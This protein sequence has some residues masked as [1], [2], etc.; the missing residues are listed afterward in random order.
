MAL[1]SPLGTPLPVG[2]ATAA[3]RA[4]WSD[5]LGRAARRFPLYWLLLSAFLAL[6][7]IALSF[8][9]ISRADNPNSAGIA[10][11]VAVHGIALGLVVL[12]ALRWPGWCRRAILTLAVA[13]LPVLA[14]TSQNVLAAGS[15]AILLGTGLWFGRELAAALLGEGDR[16]ETWLYGS[17]LGIGALGALG[18]VLGLVGWL[19]PQAIWPVVVATLLML[20]ARARGRLRDD[21]RGAARWLARPVA[22]DPLLLLL[23][24]IA[25]ASLW[26]NLLGA[27]APEV[28]SDATR[29]RLAA[30]V[31]FARSGSITPT[32]PDLDQATAPAF[33]EIAYALT[34]AIGTAQSPKLFHW[35]AGV[36][37][38]LAIFAL[39]RRLGGERA[40]FL[41]AGTSYAT[42]LVGYVAQ[43]A[44][45]DLIVTFFAVVSS[46]A[47]VS[48]QE[49]RW[50][51]AALAG[52]GAGLGVAVKVQFGYVA[53]G[54]AVIAAIVA[55]WEGRWHAA[56]RAAVLALVALLAALP[57]LI[58]SYA[59]TGEVPGL[60]FGILSLTGQ[61]NANPLVLPELQN[62]GYGRSLLRLI[63]VP[64]SAILMSRDFGGSQLS[65]LG[66]VGGHIGF[67]LLATV[68]LLFA[69]RL[70]RASAA[71]LAGSLVA[72]LGWF[73]TAQYLRYAMPILAILAALGAAAFVTVARRARDRHGR[74]ALTALLCVIV[75]AGASARVQLPDTALRFA[76]GLQSRE[77]YLDDE[78]GSDAAGS[79]QI[80]QLLNAEPSA[81]RA[82]V[83]Q[84]GA[85]LYSRVRLSHP[86]TTGGDLVF[87]GSDQEV[88]ARLAQGGYS[89]ILVDRIAWWGDKWLWDQMSV[90]DEDFLRCN[91][92]LVGGG[93]YSYLYRILPPEERGCKVAWARGGE[94]LADGSFEATGTTLGPDWAATGGARLDSSG[95]YSRSGRGAVL[96]PRGGELQTS[97]TIRPE[98]QYLLSAAIQGADGYGRIVLLIEWRDA[99]GRVIGETE[100]AMPTTPRKYRTFSILA[101]A[102]AGATT[103]VVRARAISG[104]IWFDD[105][106]LRSVEDDTT[107]SK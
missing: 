58:R 66:L 47:L 42:V 53:I 21:L 94:L 29:Q 2:S 84:D 54:L 51:M 102:P 7:D 46:L 83:M 48:R 100:E 16:L 86:W 91:T 68:P 67:A 79:Y 93:N 26:L 50:R 85:R 77:E 101:S 56:R 44:Y 105:F 82:F 81:T 98:R 38:A 28:R 14:V 92:A 107:T 10:I 24:G 62:F 27:L 64:F 70:R 90:T 22:R 71:L 33:G 63:V 11:N 57:W 12:L 15:L 43:T 35:F 19:R 87:L 49:G 20:V 45:L 1:D 37:C 32:D 52:V 106:S 25:L 39:G 96:L 103:A 74:A 104:T 40:G 9:I 61:G 99:A 30:A 18:F 80:F 6:G 69:L 3:S 5:W 75:L 97:A 31:Q 8:L 59:L 36:L 13:P 41:A 72:L 60:E 73:Y 76:L 23:V 4:R 89:H 95:A 55:L 17:V 34:V 65:A 78:L 88:L